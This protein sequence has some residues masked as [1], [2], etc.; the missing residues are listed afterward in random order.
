MLQVFWENRDK[1]EKANHVGRAINNIVLNK[2]TVKRN[3][4]TFEFQ[5]HL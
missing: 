4:G 3:D 2:T 1:I 5:S